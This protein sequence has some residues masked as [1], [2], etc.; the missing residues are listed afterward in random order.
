M[1][2]RRP[3][4]GCP[5]YCA[6]RCCRP[7]TPHHH[8]HAYAPAER[9]RRAIQSNAARKPD[10]D[11][12]GVQQTTNAP[13]SPTHRH[14]TVSHTTPTCHKHAHA[15]AHIAAKVRRGARHAPCASATII[16]I[17]QRPQH[18]AC[19]CNSAACAA[20][21][22]GGAA[23]VAAVA[24]QLSSFSCLVVAQHRAQH[25]KSLLRTQQS[26]GQC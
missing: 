6:A 9:E 23:A 14:P 7:T 17:L 5:V 24:T 4:S 18:T 19:A 26:Y 1:C 16:S 11:G 15:H 22:Q 21:G 8:L 13:Q 12:K 2:C 3:P 10:H 25:A 20:K